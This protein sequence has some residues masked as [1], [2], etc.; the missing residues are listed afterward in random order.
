[1]GRIDVKQKIKVYEVNDEEVK[2][3]KDI[4][5]TVD[6]HR[7][8]NDMVIVRVGRNRYTVDGDDLLTAIKNAMNTGGV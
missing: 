1:M 6:S 4:N 5:M 7:N 8:D 2:L 3:G